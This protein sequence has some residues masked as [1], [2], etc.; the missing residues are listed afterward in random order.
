MHSDS[1]NQWDIPPSA[2]TTRANVQDGRRVRNSGTK[3]TAREPVCG[4]RSTEGASTCGASC[5]HRRLPPLPPVAAAD[6]W[7]SW[8]KSWKLWLLDNP[9]RCAPRRVSEFGSAASRIS[10]CRADLSSSRGTGGG[11]IYNP[12]QDSWQQGGEGASLPPLQNIA[13]AKVP[14]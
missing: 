11:E 3:M 5:C 8:S 2:G 9:R 6:S 7:N 14:V 4:I 12:W 10:N 13:S 1:H